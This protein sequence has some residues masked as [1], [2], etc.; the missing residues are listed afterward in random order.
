MT[1]S[2]IEAAEPGFGILP[3]ALQAPALEHWKN[4]AEAARSGGLPSP[5]GVVAASAIGVWALSDF[6]AKSCIRNPD[7]FAGLSATGDL[8]RSYEADEFATRVHAALEPA[9]DPD[10]LGSRLRTLR[11][12]EMVRIAWRDLAGWADLHETMQDLSLFAEACISGA[13]DWL[14]LW[15]QKELGRP[16]DRT[17]AP[18]SLVVL[19]MGKLGGGELNFSSDVDL[20]FAYPAQGVTASGQRGVSNAEYFVRLARRFINAIGASGP[21][22][23]VFRVDTRLR[24]F[25]ESGP[26]V[27]SF[28]AMEHYYQSQGREWERYA[29]IKARPVS[30]DR[31][32]VAELLDTLR[33]FVYRRYLDYGAFDALREM[34][35]LIAEETR[36]KGLRDDIKLG[37]GGIRE[38]EFIAQTFQLIRGGKIPEL[39]E[40]STLR[41]L[42]LVADKGFLPQDVRAALE[43][44]YCFLR[45]TEHRLQEFEDRQTHRLPVDSTGRMRLALSMGYPDWRAFKTVLDAHQELVHRHFQGLFAAGDEDGHEDRLKGL[46]RGIWSGGLDGSSAHRLLSGMGFQNPDA[47]SQRLHVLR[48]SRRTQAMGASGRQRLARLIPAVLETAART[49]D[50]DTA[51]ERVLRVIDAVG[52]RVIYLSLLVENPQVL[53]HLTRL[54]AQG[55]WVTTLL[56]RHP[57]LLDELL[58]P[59]HLHPR[60]DRTEL[61]SALAETL[62]G[63]PADD[64]EAQMD[65][66]RHFKQANLLRVA[67]ADVAGVLSVQ[68]VSNHLTDLAETIVARALSLSWHHMRRRH[69]LPPGS[70]NASDPEEAIRGFAIVAYG[71]LGARELSYSSDLDLVF[72]HAGTTG[73]PTRGPKPLDPSLFYTRLGQRTIHILTTPT[74]AGTLYEVDMRLRPSGASGVLVI[75]L[76]AFF[77]YQLREAWTWEHQALVRARAIAGDSEICAK[78]EALRRKLIIRP[79]EIPTLKTAVISM[80]ENIVR[81]LGSRRRDAF[82][83]KHDPGG[84]VDTEFLVQFLV[85]AN[86]PEHPELARWTSIEDL[87]RVLTESGLLDKK[88]AEILWQASSEYRKALHQRSLQEKPQAI[89]EGDAFDALRTEVLAVWERLMAP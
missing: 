57:I 19:G 11:R 55:A 18:Q 3:E 65:E 77:E 31:R 2:V 13:V 17:G 34:K 80:R 6:V 71:K 74:P 83:L 26:L 82:D 29:M 22:G 15:Q 21:E 48:T 27:M 41:A 84:L 14:H 32:A 51:L 89:L 68:G 79:R 4:F 67:A 70:D 38:I 36:R 87:L 33:P 43:K 10:S 35:Q 76:D 16:V 28:D 49:L 60:S 54:C 63:T 64:L 86:A 85:L 46:L 23:L 81:E 75:G 88:T 42:R 61:E 59:R 12:R 73:T 72:L 66:L 50:P 47:A 78:F 20:I 9:E 62:A 39:Q 69:G 30:G 44:A 52:R 45:A 58:D 37:R 7:I 24:P 8:L 40:R 53:D 5:D 56:A 1:E 25:G